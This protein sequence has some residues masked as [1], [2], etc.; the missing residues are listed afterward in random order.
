MDAHFQMPCSQS[1]HSLCSLIGSV[2]GYSTNLIG[3]LIAL[4]PALL[5]FRLH[6]HTESPPPNIA[7]IIIG[8]VNLPHS[9][10]LWRFLLYALGSKLAFS[11]TKNNVIKKLGGNEKDVYMTFWIN[12]SNIVATCPLLAFSRGESVVADVPTISPSALTHFIAANAH[13]SISVASVY[14]SS[15]VVSV[16]E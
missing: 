13:V 6:R 15:S 16:A 2:I 11:N 5:K 9:C 14:L 10:L 3:K 8:L 1:K 4:V 7:S 12:R